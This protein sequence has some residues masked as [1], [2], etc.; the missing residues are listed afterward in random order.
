MGIIAGLLAQNLLKYSLNFGEVAYLLSYNAFVNFFDNFELQ[1]S[2][3]CNDDNCVKLQEKF[4]KGELKSRKLAPKVKEEEDKKEGIIS[5]NEWGIIVEE[6]I[7]E[8]KPEKNKKVEA[9]TDNLSLE[10][11]QKQLKNLNKK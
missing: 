1:P 4:N 2:S 5:T 8:S 9:K 10:D 7:D 11:L 3:T 6:E